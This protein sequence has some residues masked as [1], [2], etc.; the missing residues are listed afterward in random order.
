MEISKA[1]AT[2][3]HGLAYLANAKAQTPM[4]V[5]EIALKL[6]FSQ[7]YLAKIFQRLSHTNLVYSRRGPRGGYVSAR[8]PDKINLLEIIEAIDGPFSIGQCQLGPTGRCPMLERCMIRTELDK[9]KLQIRK[10]YE[11][12]TLSVFAQ[13]FDGSDFFSPD[14]GYLAS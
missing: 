3:I 2:G 1:A 5:K 7:A 8:E 4:D 9:V 12:I 6:G 11:G 10:L 13:Q 14:S